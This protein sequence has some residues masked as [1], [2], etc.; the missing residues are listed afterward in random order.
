MATPVPQLRRHP[1]ARRHESRSRRSGA[2]AG[3][4]VV[5]RATGMDRGTPDLRNRAR[6][7]RPAGDRLRGRP[8]TDRHHG[9]VMARRPIRRD[10]QR[11]LRRPD[12]RRTTSRH[13]MAIAGVRRR[14]VGRRPFAALRP[15]DPDCVRRAAG[16][17]AAGHRGTTG[18]AIAHGTHP[19]R[20]R[21]EP[22]RVG[23]VRRCRRPWSHHHGPLR[24]GA[25]RRGAGDAA[26]AHRAGHRPTH[27]LRGNGP[28]RANHDRPRIPIRPDRRLAR[29][30][31]PCIGDRGGRA[32]R[33]PADRAVPLLR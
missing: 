9:R 6:R 31:H 26:A 14:S 27:P 32:L 21:A 5:P 17:P 28:L 24:R 10:R 22:G 19:G 1:P 7:P 29:R 30:A 2:G 23:A 3:Q 25:R 15:C 18:L 16:P 20:L 12:R 13:C 33:P 11:S 8:P 4:R